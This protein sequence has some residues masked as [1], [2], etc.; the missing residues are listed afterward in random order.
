MPEPWTGTTTF[1]LKST[2]TIDTLHHSCSNTTTV[3]N[4]KITSAEFFL[5]LD[6]IQKCLGRTYGEQEV[7]LASMAKKQKVEVKEKDLTPE[8]RKEFLAAKN[9]EIDSWLATDTVRKNP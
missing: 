9:K 4:G 6:E 3:E 8:E 7:F 5:S 2:S 1:P